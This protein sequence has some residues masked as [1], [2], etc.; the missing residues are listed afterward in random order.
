[1]VEELYQLGSM[2][3]GSHISAVASRGIC[4]EGR[5]KVLISGSHNDTRFMMRVLVEM[6]GY[7]VLEANGEEETMNAAETF[8]PNAILLDATR[9]FDEDLKIVSRL[10]LSQVSRLVPIIV[11]SGYTQSK[12]HEAAIDRGAT[13]LLAKPL[14]LD[15]LEDCLEAALPV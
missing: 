7:E 6:W 1:V 11:L 10:R 4:M 14:D 3:F 12:Y 8:L 15:Q 9:L 5:G 2:E 13:K